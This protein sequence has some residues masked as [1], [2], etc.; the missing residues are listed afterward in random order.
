[1]MRRLVESA[2]LNPESSKG[3]ALSMKV[4]SEYLEFSD[5]VRVVAQRV[6]FHCTGELPDLGL[7]TTPCDVTRWRGVVVNWFCLQGAMIHPIRTKYKRPW[8]H[9]IAEEFLYEITFRM[10]ADEYYRRRCST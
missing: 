4:I 1:M 3:L 9:L 5:D 8:G 10:P 7:I 2:T 6:I